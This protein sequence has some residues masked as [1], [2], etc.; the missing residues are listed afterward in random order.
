MN[1]IEVDDCN[2]YEYIH[3]ISNPE[4]VA[5]YL[6][7][8]VGWGEGIEGIGIYKLCEDGIWRNL[9]SQISEHEKQLEFL[10]SV[11]NNI[12]SM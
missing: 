10:K 4:E 6:Y 3:I 9:D 8:Q 1:I 11:K 2:R 5:G 12:E 7:H